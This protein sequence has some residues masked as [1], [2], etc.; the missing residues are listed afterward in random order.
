MGFFR[1]QVTAAELGKILAGAVA[2]TVHIPVDDIP[3]IGDLIERTPLDEASARFEL[4]C[5]IAVVFDNAVLASITS[6]RH[7]EDLL[8]SFYSSLK[9]FLGEWTGDT[10]RAEKALISRIKKYYEALEAGRLASGTPAIARAFM[11]AC[12]GEGGDNLD[13]YVMFTAQTTALLSAFSEQ[14]HKMIKQFKIV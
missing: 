3:I 7:R 4:T 10:K 1:K 12:I 13:D 2:M 5:L 8:N 6:V 11:D 14:A 9:D